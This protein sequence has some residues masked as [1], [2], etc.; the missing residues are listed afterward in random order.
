M[1]CWTP[2]SSDFLHRKGNSTGRTRIQTFL[3]PLVNWAWPQALVQHCIRTKD[4]KISKRKTHMCWAFMR[5]QN[6]E[7]ILKRHWQFTLPFWTWTVWERV[8]SGMWL[9]SIP[10][11]FCYAETWFLRNGCSPVFLHLP[12]SLPPNVSI[13][14][15][16][17]VKEIL[18]L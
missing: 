18:W 3:G 4:G 15:L 2:K 12:V 5:I 17:P 9:R 14:V 8:V 1:L 13:A 11:D 7:D 6:T 16:S 10:R